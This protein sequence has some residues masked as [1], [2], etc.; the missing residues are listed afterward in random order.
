MSNHALR[1]GSDLY[2][3]T[4]PKTLRAWCISRCIPR[5]GA[6]YTDNPIFKLWLSGGWGTN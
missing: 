3:L 4:T 6:F 5:G 2:G 1:V